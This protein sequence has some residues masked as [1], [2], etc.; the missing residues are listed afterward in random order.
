MQQHGDDHQYRSDDKGDPRSFFKSRIHILHEDK[1]LLMA[2]PPEYS[3][4][5]GL[6]A[7]VGNVLVSGLIV[8]THWW[9]A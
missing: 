8:G 4:H 1:E 6:D 9:K 7:V 2:F 3:S 5:F